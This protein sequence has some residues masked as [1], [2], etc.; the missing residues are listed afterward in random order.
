MPCIN[1][2]KTKFTFDIDIATETYQMTKISSSSQDII[3]IYRS[4]GAPSFQFS[5]DLR[6]MFNY[7]KET[8]IVGDLNICFA[9]ERTHLVLQDIEKLG[10]TQKVQYPTHREGR[11]IDHVYI[12]SPDTAVKSNVG[13]FQQSPFF[14]DH[15]ILFVTQVSKY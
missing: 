8:L 6:T 15:D 12:F 10:F 2:F 1:K 3:N 11:Q 5:S 9:N 14:S 7:E 13:V 4:Q